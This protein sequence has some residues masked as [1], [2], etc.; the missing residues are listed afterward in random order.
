VSGHARRFV[1]PFVAQH[2]DDDLAARF[3]RQQ[4]D[5]THLE[6]IL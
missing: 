4:G 3:E 2:V 1:D 5:K 6:V